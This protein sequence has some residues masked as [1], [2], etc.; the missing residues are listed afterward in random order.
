MSLQAQKESTI[1]LENKIVKWGR[2]KVELMFW[3]K[4]NFKYLRLHGKNMSIELEKLSLPYN[5]SQWFQMQIKTEDE[6]SQKICHQ[7]LTKV[8]AFFDY[9]S[10]TLECQKV[11]QR[12]VSEANQSQLNKDSDKGAKEDSSTELNKTNETYESENDCD[13]RSSFESIT[14][15]RIDEDD[16]ARELFEKSF[17]C[18]VYVSEA[19]NDPDYDRGSE[20]PSSVRSHSES[21]NSE[22]NDEDD[23]ASEIDSFDCTV[24]VSEGDIVSPN[25]EVPGPSGL[26]QGQKQSPPI[27]LKAPF[28]R[29]DL[30]DSR[31]ETDNK[32]KSE[33]NISPVD[34]DSKQ[35]QNHLGNI[36]P[37]I[38]FK[39]AEPTPKE[40]FKISRHEEVVNKE[41][42]KKNLECNLCQFTARYKS[43]LDIHIKRHKKDYKIFCDICQKGFFYQYEILM[44]KALHE[45]TSRFQCNVCQKKFVY[46]HS[47]ISH[48]RKHEEV[49]KPSETFQ[50]DKC[51]KNFS[52]KSYLKRHKD[53]HSGV[54]RVVCEVCGQ[55]LCTPDALRSHS[56]T[57]TGERPF[58]CGICGKS[59]TSKKYM[60]IH[61]RMHT[62]A[63]PFKCKVCEKSFSQQSTLIV[64][65][66]YH[67][68]ERPYKCQVCHKAFVTKTILKVHQK[69]HTA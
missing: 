6:V 33:K 47:L 68:G 9:R 44:H 62:G 54:N 20:V 67:S 64:H 43:Q 57:H 3:K 5:Q 45:E 14:S 32:K 4:K 52:D 10:T 49:F 69:S 7:C 8:N 37:P 66:R 39:T 19:A 17:D 29:N 51:G 30:E 36:C 61:K 21:I 28:R 16:V 42:T 13:S 12:W 22:R 60:I 34:Q 2:R 1:N 41:C 31:G 53:V 23:V 46:R 58:S 63:K 18:T 48:T 15:E 11:L 25:S 50:C 55:V 24:N 27:E 56:L 38:H 59:F 65:N 40:V 26:Q 35:N